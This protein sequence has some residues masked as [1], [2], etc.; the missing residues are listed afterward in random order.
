[1]TCRF[2]TEGDEPPY[3]YREALPGRK[4][5]GR[6]AAAKARK[7]SNRRRRKLQDKVRKLQAKA[8]KR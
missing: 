8:G 6:H 2:G 4:L 1:M 3:C 7:D 5:C